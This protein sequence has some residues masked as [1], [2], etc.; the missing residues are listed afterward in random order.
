M[1]RLRHPA[2][3]LVPFL[4]GCGT[5]RM[6]DTAR[7]AT[8]MLLVSQAADK[9]VVQID[10]TPLSGKTVF[11]D[12]SSIPEKDLDKGYLVSLI[13]QQLLSTG[14]LLHDEKPRAEYV[15]ELRSG[16]LGTDRRSMLLGTPAV[17]L[18]SV[19]P[20]IPTSVPEIAL[21]KKNDQRGIAKIGVFAYSRVT[22]RALWQSGTVEAESR[23]NDTWVFGAGPFTRGSILKRSE[24]AGEPLP[25][26]PT[27]IFGGNTHPT[28][29][30][31]LGEQYFPNSQ[32]PLP[33]PVI[34][35]GLLGVTGAAVLADKP[36][37]R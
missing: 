6:T 29:T 34:P 11:L 10:F 23:V 19:V 17:Q 27:T 35:A 7:S 18:P 21:L 28:T 32:M 9:A 20:G 22:G 1:T 12:A 25:T 4:A 24:L 15:V 36:V 2:L 37:V 8:E 5:T 14:A 3:L 31:P 33:S 16:G 13:R 30:N 26:I